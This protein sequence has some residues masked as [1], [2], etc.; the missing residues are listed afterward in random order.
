MQ[1]TYHTRHFG[2]AREE[3]SQDIVSFHDVRADAQVDKICPGVLRTGKLASALFH[4]FLLFTN[5]TFKES[6]TTCQPLYPRA[7][8]VMPYLCLVY[9][10]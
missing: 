9:V 4:S 3:K 7:Y 1:L 8:T 6:D 5:S 2:T 10:T